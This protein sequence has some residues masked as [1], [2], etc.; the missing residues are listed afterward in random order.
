MRKKDELSNPESCMSKA[1][2]DE[3]T[4]VLLGRDRA[5]PFAIQSWVEERVRLGK[6]TRTDAQIVEA[7]ACADIM[8][9]ERTALLRSSSLIHKT[10]F[11]IKATEFL[12]EHANMDKFSPEDWAKMAVINQALEILGKQ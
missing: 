10:E 11:F 7:L 3:M 8:E 4:F 1:R 2:Q 12:K 9:R 5:A 6:N